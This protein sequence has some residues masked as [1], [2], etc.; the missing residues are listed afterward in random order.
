MRGSA[1][2][3]MPIPVSVTTTDREGRATLAV[4]RDYASVVPLVFLGTRLP[5]GDLGRHGVDIAAFTAVAWGAAICDEGQNIKNARAQAAK[6]RPAD[7]QG[8]VFTISNL[9]MFNVDTF[10]AIIVPPQVG[11]LA[12]GAIVDRVV[13][14]DGRLPSS[15]ITTIT[16][17]T[18]DDMNHRTLRRRAA[19][20]SP[21]LRA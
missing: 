14:V 11:I 5:G 10:T 9:G 12:V 1:S 6:L 3:G 20:A 2:A 15:S 8:G 19:A 13:V 18:G 4:R 16:A 21:A 7:I 17:H